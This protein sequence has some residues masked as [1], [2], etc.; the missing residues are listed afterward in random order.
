MVIH[1]LDTA[2][3][4]WLGVVASCRP[5]FVKAGFM[6]SNHG[7]KVASVTTMSGLGHLVRIIS[8]PVLTEHIR[9]TEAPLQIVQEDPKGLAQVIWGLLCRDPKQFKNTNH[10][11]RL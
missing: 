3:M 8:A 7:R 6:D 10:L 9:E 5:A 2:L 1:R 4:A 11:S